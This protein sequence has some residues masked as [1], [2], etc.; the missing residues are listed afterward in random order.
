M[1]AQHARGSSAVAELH[2]DL[3]R[4]D[5]RIRRGVGRDD[6]TKEGASN[7]DN[8]GEAS[9]HKFFHR[10]IFPARAPAG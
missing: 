9:Q 1:L 2:E 6:G 10:P 7:H 4:R 3:P 5:R 8:S